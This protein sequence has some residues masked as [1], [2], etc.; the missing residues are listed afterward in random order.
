MFDKSRL[1]DALIQY[2][3][4]FVPKHWREEK[5]KWEAIKHFQDNWDVN[6]NDFAEMLNLALS[7]TDKL[8]TGPKYF[9]AGMITGFASK[10]P[11]EVR[12]MYIDLFD[13]SEDLYARINRFKTKSSILLEKYGNGAAQHYQYENAISVY[14]WLRYPEKYYVYKF[15]EVKAVSDELKSDYRF[16]KGAYA[17]NI[18]NFYQFYNE[19]CEELKEDTELVNLFKSQLTPDL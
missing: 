9:P 5:F 11:E 8:L 3:K 10:A 12:A 16:K 6:A 7:K 19:I 4:D 14:L 13:E 17:D 2:K 18:R 15:N 1:K